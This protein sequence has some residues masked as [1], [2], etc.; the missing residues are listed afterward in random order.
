MRISL[1]KRSIRPS[2]VSM[3]MLRMSCWLVWPA[4]LTDRWLVFSVRMTA[5]P[6]SLS[7]HRWFGR[8]PALALQAV[9]V[10]GFQQP[11]VSATAARSAAVVFCPSPAKSTPES[12]AQ[13]RKI[14]QISVSA[15]VGNKQR[16]VWLSGRAPRVP[17]SGTVRSQVPSVAI[18]QFMETLSQA[19][20]FLP[21]VNCIGSAGKLPPGG[22]LPANRQWRTGRPKFLAVLRSIG[23]PAPVA[24]FRC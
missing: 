16:L 2:G 13:L 21:P 23:R 15:I 4:R 10:P 11:P 17:C 9:D 5:R 8:I 7:R 6:A 14:R 20:Y 24:R 22:K 1:S 3:L 12:F 18:I 19:G